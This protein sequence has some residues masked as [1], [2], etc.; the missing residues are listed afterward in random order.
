M[1]AFDLGASGVMRP[2]VALAC[3]QR[4]SQSQPVFFFQAEDGIRDL[5]VTGV[6]TCALPIYSTPVPRKSARSLDSTSGASDRERG[7]SSRVD[8]CASGPTPA[9]PGTHPASAPASA[10]EIGRASCRERV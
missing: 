8:P 6:Q 5:T 7:T 4:R 10:R 9:H 3:E 1:V 2:V